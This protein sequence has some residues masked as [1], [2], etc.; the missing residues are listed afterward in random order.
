MAWVASPM[1]KRALKYSAVSVISI[2]VSQVVL[3][4]TFGIA[5]LGSAVECNVIATAVATVPS[6][7]LNRRWAWGKSGSSH[8]WRE[9][10]PFWVIAFVGLA[11]SLVAV[12]L[13]DRVGK[14]LGLSHLGISLLVNAASLASYGL[15][16]I[17]KFLV[18]NRFLF[19][20]HGPSLELVGTAG[21]AD[22]NG[23]GSIDSGR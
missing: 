12:A 7:N 19:V 11:V 21:S 10:V 9:V 23:A 15:L 4:L 22:T 18:F 5:R 16:W 8:V 17:G 1:G 20:D 13:A 3:F 2:V 14:S 6:Y